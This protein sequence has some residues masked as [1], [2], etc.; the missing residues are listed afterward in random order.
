MLEYPTLQFY[1]FCMGV[2]L[3]FSHKVKNVPLVLELCIFVYIL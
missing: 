3:G 2:K 1:L